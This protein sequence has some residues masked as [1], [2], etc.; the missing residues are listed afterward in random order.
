MKKTTTEKPLSSMES[1]KV[2]E[3]G[4]CGL[5]WE[6]FVEKISFESGVKKCRKQMSDAHFPALAGLAGGLQVSETVMLSR[7]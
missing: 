3:C 5:W 6:G 2:V 1:M 7:S 4:E